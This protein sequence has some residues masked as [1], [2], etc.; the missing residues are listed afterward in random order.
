MIGDL[1]KLVRQGVNDL[2]ILSSNRFAA[3]GWSKTEC[4]K[5]RTHGRDDFGVTAIRLVVEWV[6]QR[7]QD[8][9]GMVAPVA[10][11]SPAW[12]RW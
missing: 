5:V 2:I 11:A 3:S 7:C 1:G 9:L 10:A 12:R 6:R 8:A 4:N